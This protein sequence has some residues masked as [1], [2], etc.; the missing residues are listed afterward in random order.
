MRQKFACT[1]AAI[2][3]GTLTPSVGAPEL[4]SPLAP[5][6]KPGWY[7][8]L[9]GGARVIC[10]SF[11]AEMEKG[12]FANQLYGNTVISW[13]HGF[14]TAYNEVLSYSPQI[15][16]DLSQGLDEV[17]V[18]NWVAD[19]CGRHR[20][21]LIPDAAHEMIVY[22]FQRRLNSNPNFQDSR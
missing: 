20:D 18:I 10:G 6:P 21:Q 5:Q 17:E 2:L 14:L 4:P 16:G 12:P 11:V 19:Y 7:K 13:V 15:G 22:L 3:L 9:G 1:L 8:A